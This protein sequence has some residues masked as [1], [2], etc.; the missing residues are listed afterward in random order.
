MHVYVA[1]ARVCASP[2]SSPCLSLYV[3][4]LLCMLLLLACSRDTPIKTNDLVTIHILQSIQLYSIQISHVQIPQLVR[5]TAVPRTGTRTGSDSRVS[6]RT[7]YY[8][9]TCTEL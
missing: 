3:N 9:G 1:I 5:S 8:H 4:G 6:T 7:D 2:V